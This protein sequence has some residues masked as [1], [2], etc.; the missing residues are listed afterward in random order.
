MILPN[1][2][3]ET[4]SSGGNQCVATEH[5]RQLKRWINIDFSIWNLHNYYTQNLANILQVKHGMYVQCTS[6]THCKIIIECNWYSIVCFQLFIHRC[7]FTAM[8]TLKTVH[9]AISTIKMLYRIFCLPLLRTSKLNCN[10]KL[11]FLN[12]SDHC[13]YISWR[14]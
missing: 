5:S 3:N 2:G 4:E 1:T 8:L 13:I 14:V 9:D 11:S 10:C 7:N 12:S 6:Y